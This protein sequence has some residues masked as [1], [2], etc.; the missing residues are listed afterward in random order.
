MGRKYFH[1]SGWQRKSDGKVREERE[2]VDPK[3]FNQKYVKQARPV[4][5]RGLVK[6]APVLKTWA[7]DKNM[8]NK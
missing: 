8:K 7:E 6:D 1:F 3:S 5:L 2:G 4:V